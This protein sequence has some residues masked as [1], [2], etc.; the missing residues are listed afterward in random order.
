MNTDW[1]QELFINEAKPAMKRHSTSGGD[2]MTINNQDKTITENGEYTHDAGY[3][4]L[5][6]VTVNVE[7]SGGGD[8]VVE[9]IIAGDTASI[10]EYANDN[11]TILRPYAFHYCRS[12]TKVNLP[13]LKKMNRNAFSD[14]RALPSVSFPNLV[15]MDQGAFNWAMALE[16][17]DMGK[18]PNLYNSAFYGARM[19]KY[20]VLRKTDSITA[21]NAT[22]VFA[23]TKYNTA[24]EI[25][26]VLVPNAL[27]PTYQQATN[28]SSMYAKG[29]CVF[30]P[31]EDYT[32]DGTVTGE[33]DWDKINALHE[34][35]SA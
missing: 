10:V 6:K 33:I 25:G 11:I 21:V 12:L 26:Y 3:T 5:G 15:Y 4:G 20:L 31:L 1:L 35:A 13:N 9:S 32:V 18:V 30:V 14:C 29:S 27:I 16:F 28:W 24:G 2:D 19:L 7:A 22:N 23:E 17:A 8:A 34:E